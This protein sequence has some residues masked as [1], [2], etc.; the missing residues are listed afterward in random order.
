MAKRA[1]ALFVGN[2]KYP[3]QALKNPVNDARAIAEKLKAFD[4]S[5]I[6]YGAIDKEY[7]AVFE[8]YF[9]PPATFAASVPFPFQ[10]LEPFLAEC[11]LQI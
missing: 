6:T 8:T 5:Q 4:G 7:R 10:M 11:L 1:L 9:N 3:A 2:A